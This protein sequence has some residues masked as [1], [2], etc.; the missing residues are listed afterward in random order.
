MLDI[1]TVV[2]FAKVFCRTD[3]VCKK[4]FSSILVIIHPID[5]HFKK[6]SPVISITLN[7]AKDSITTKSKVNKEDESN[8]Q[9]ENELNYNFFTAGVIDKMRL[10]M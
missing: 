1:S 6:S 4:T 8:L 2:S 9:D 5:V 3:I 10:I 7:D